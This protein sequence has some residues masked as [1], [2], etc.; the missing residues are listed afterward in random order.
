MSVNQQ[1]EATVLDVIQTVE[2][3]NGFSR[4]LLPSRA[5]VFERVSLRQPELGSTPELA[6]MRS[7]S[8]LY[9]LYFEAGRTSVKHLLR[10]RVHLKEHSDLVHALRTWSQHNL[11]TTSARAADIERRCTDW[12]LLE[13]GTRVP[14]DDLHWRGLCQSLLSAAKHFL[15]D[16]FEGIALIEADPAC[17][18]LIEDWQRSLSRDWPAHKYHELIGSAASDGG[19]SAIDPV[20]FYNRYGDILRDRL[21][22]VDDDCDYELEIRRLV[23]IKLVSESEQALPCTGQDIMQHFG[24]GPGP[25][26]GRLLSEA[27]RLHV[28]FGPLS[29]AELLDRLEARERRE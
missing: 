2:K 28:E 4:A 6:F 1:L 13:C 22:L 27:K 10:S 23:E 15:E 14:R 12:F 7:I 24:I 8:W 9:V 29:M 25:D 20:K 5:E 17:D 3:I 19:F 21:Q 26:V 16:L 11:D 18:G